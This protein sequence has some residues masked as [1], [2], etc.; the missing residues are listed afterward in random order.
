MIAVSV[1][2]G[3]RD[4]IGAGLRLQLVA[5]NGDAVEVIG[6]AVTDDSGVATFDVDGSAFAGL[7]VRLDPTVLTPPSGV[8]PGA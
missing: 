8:E 1:L 2:S 7:A 5:K 6:C 3:T 4:P